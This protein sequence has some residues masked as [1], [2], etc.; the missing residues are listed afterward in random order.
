[1]IVRELATGTERNVVV[2]GVKLWRVEVEPLGHWAKVYAI[3]KDT[4]GDGKL[5]WPSVRTSLSARGCRGPISSYSTGGWNGDQPDELWL[6]VT[7]AKM[8]AKRGSD[9]AEPP[10][11]PELGSVGDR[12]IL[13]VDTAGKQL[14]APARADWRTL[15]EGPLEWVDAPADKPK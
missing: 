12:R 6:D 15:P 1:M 4:D 10:E 9:P 8:V 14:L 3:R 11:D 5:T 13:A 7:T 2:P